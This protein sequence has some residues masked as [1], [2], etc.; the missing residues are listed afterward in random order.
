[1]TMGPGWN[2]EDLQEFQNSLPWEW[3]LIRDDE[4]EDSSSSD[5]DVEDIDSTWPSLQSSDKDNNYHA[6]KPESL[7]DI[8]GESN[9][10]EEE[11][12]LPPLRPARRTWQTS[13]NDKNIGQTK[14]RDP[15]RLTDTEKLCLGRC[16]LGFKVGPDTAL[17][18]FGSGRPSTNGCLAFNLD[19][20][21]FFRPQLAGG[22]KLPTPRFTSAGVLFGDHNSYL[23]V[24]GGYSS[25]ESAAIGDL[26]V[27][28]LAPAVERDLFVLEEDDDYEAYDPVTQTDVDRYNQRGHGNPFGH[29]GIPEE[30]EDLI[31]MVVEGHPAGQGARRARDPGEMAAQMLGGMVMEMG[32]PPGDH[33]PVDDGDEDDDPRAFMMNMLAQGMMGVRNCSDV[34]GF[35]CCSMM[36][37]WRYPCL[38]PFLSSLLTSLVNKQ[39]IELD[40][41][42]FQMA[43]AMGIFAND[44]DESE[45]A[46]YDNSDDASESDDSIP[47][48]S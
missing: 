1:M 20:N 24:Q 11:D 31:R 7:Q 4:D 36:L 43:M 22:G 18:V 8:D 10:Y 13:N 37:S 9:D 35:I 47:E 12:S 25:Q 6:T 19:K 2:S 26:C 17:L 38:T 30:V 15:N 46:D 27:L 3:E 29:G 41:D 14:G 42:E 32:G 39:Q 33:G 44:D 16:H 5:D 21:E 40:D 28:D 34:V 23:L 48:L 45:E